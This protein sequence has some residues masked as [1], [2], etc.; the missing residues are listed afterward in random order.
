[1]KLLFDQNLAP[2]LAEQLTDLFPGSLH[3]R[4]LG[5]READDLQI[6]NHARANGLIIATKDVDFDNLA[7]ARGHPPK[8]LLIRLGNCPVSMVERL[9]RAYHEQIEAFATDP[10]LSI[11]RIP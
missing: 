2:K 8:V 4:K 5:M 10:K 6:W 11:L 3:V 9:L 1:M 7:V